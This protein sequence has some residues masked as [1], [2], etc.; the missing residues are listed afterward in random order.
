MKSIK[1][2]T[3]LILA[4]LFI[5]SLVS[6]GTLNPAINSDSDTDTTTQTDTDT[7]EGGIG[8]ETDTETENETF[9]DET[10]Y[11]DSAF[12][13]ALR[14]NGVKYIPSSDVVVTWKNG[15]TLETSTINSK[16]YAGSERLDGDYKVTISG[17]PEDKV[18]NPNIYEATNDKR[19]VIIDVLDFGSY[20]GRGKD[21]YNGIRLS[22]AGV[23][24]VT[25]KDAKEIVYFDFFPS[26][27]GMYGIE[28]WIDVGEGKYN[29][30]CDVYLGTTVYKN[31]DQTVDGGG[32][33]GVYTKNFKTGIN[34][35]DDMVG[36][37]LTFGIHTDAISTDNY[38]ATIV[39]AVTLDGA[40][41]L[42]TNHEYDMYVPEDPYAYVDGSVFYDSSYEV[43]YA[44][45]PI[46]GRDGAY[47]FVNANYKLWPKEE[48]G[49][50]YYHVYNEEKYSRENY[51]NGYKDG[52]PEGYGPILYA[53]ITQPTRFIENPLSNFEV[54]GKPLSIKV[55]DDLRLNY[56]HYIEGYSNLARRVW[57]GQI[58]KYLSSYYCYI[59]CP[60]HP[61][62]QIENFA[63]LE[64][65]TNCL[66]LC[67]NVKREF[68][69][70]WDENGNPLSYFEG[71][72]AYSTLN[73]GVAVTEELK[74]F[75]ERLSVA[76]RYFADGEGWMET[77]EAV[78]VDAADDAMWLFPCF[79]FE[80]KAN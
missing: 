14:Y 63:C 25:L 65:C 28:S 59:G 44:E 69:L 17:L 10:G 30:L 37:V 24:S 34:V 3:S 60:C 20:T 2:I 62:D 47:E 7:S 68:V 79:Y 48:N 46:A 50:G 70:S 67:R 45:T 11:S 19:N 77:H 35:N 9:G 76:Q 43:V 49:D 8:T 39:F 29:P 23:Y 38:P 75:L 55:S 57:D 74:I 6:C 80:K 36:N 22:K 54:K 41:D 71:I 15:S 27:S 64:G 72:Q 73:G 32:A 13:V 4:I 51:P 66:D 31:F 16:G 33:E 12:T 42:I 18:Y 26:K 40:F 1:K 61:A 58:Q 53:Q 52:Y 21:P 78:N 56:K 5:L